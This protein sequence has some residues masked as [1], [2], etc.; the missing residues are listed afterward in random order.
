MRRLDCCRVLRTDD[1]ACIGR[2]IQGLGATFDSDHF[3]SA[4]L[5]GDA[6]G[7]VV[8]HENVDDVGRAGDKIDLGLTPR[9]RWAICSRGSNDALSV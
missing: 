1:Q 6:R 3:M 2:A 8:C 9:E 4:E 7:V 5:L